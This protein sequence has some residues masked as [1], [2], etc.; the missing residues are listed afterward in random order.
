MWLSGE[1]AWKTRDRTCHLSKADELMYENLKIS[2]KTRS[3]TSNLR[4]ALISV[5][6]MLAVSVLTACGSSPKQTASSTPSSSVAATTTSAA[7]SNSATATQSA[8][9]CSSDT[10]SDA[11]DPGKY[12]GDILTQVRKTWKSDAV[13]SS[14]RFEDL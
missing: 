10:S 6:L 14:V 11:I 7:P 8:L 4:I 9:T 3:S 13:I 5:I 2:T 1:R 12:F